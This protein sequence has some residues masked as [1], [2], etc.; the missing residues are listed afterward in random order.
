[1]SG[2]ILLFFYDRGYLKKIKDINGNVSTIA[3]REIV[4]C[5]MWFSNKE[6]L[7]AFLESQRAI[8]MPEFGEPYDNLKT[9]VCVD[10]TNYSKKELG[11]K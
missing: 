2:P 11:L 4:K 1:M 3:K 9:T 5:R 7:N 6:E 10:G 8:S